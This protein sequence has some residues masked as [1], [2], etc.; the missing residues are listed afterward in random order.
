MRMRY[1]WTARRYSMGKHL[2]A[3]HRDPM[4]PAAM[5]CIDAHLGCTLLLGQRGSAAVGACR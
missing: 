2:M 5:P 3:I 1:V 4:G